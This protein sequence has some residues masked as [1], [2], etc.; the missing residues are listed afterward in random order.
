MMKTSIT[1]DVRYTAQ[2][3]LA[4]WPASFIFLR[5]ISGAASAASAPRSIKLKIGSSGIAKGGSTTDHTRSWLAMPLQ[6][7]HT[8]GMEFGKMLAH[9]GVVSAP[10][11]T[12]HLTVS[13]RNEGVS[14]A[15]Q[16]NDALYHEPRLVKTILGSVVPL[17]VIAA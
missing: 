15:P 16:L 6:I 8:F 3:V 1:T 2:K 9:H 10:I 14:V 13:N 7:W 11:A 5:H 17:V 4:M 12:Q